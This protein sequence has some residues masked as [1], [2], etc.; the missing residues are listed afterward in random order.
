MTGGAA[1][2]RG[3]RKLAQTIKRSSSPRRRQRA[4][5]FARSAGGKC[6]GLVAEWV[7]IPEYFGWPA[8][9]FVYATTGGHAR[10]DRHQKITGLV[11]KRTSDAS[12]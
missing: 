3:V 11:A 8:Q 4:P 12:R 2:L 9:P 7:F 10:H 5:A 1:L 6:R